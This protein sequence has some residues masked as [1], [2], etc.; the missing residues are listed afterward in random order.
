MPTTF[1]TAPRPLLGQPVTSAPPNRV[2][3]PKRWD[4]QGPEGRGVLGTEAT[5]QLLRAVSN[6]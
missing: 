6:C 4:E 5:F 3:R 2:A 1:H